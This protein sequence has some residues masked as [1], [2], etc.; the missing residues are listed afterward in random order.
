[1]A[2]T[3]HSRMTTNAA[4]ESAGVSQSLDTPAWPSLPAPAWAGWRHSPA[5]AQTRTLHILGGVALSRRLTSS[6]T[7][8]RQSLANR[9]G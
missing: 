8:R 7:D 2:S 4:L 5:F 9:P 6:E 3:Q 1:M